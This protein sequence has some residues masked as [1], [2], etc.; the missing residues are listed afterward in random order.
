MNIH[1]FLQCSYK[2]LDEPPL[3]YLYHDILYIQIEL[4][5]LNNINKLL[6]R[7]ISKSEKFTYDYVHEQ[8]TRKLRVFVDPVP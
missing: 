3:R 8:F 1:L 6:N 5:M 7:C 2:L 4:L